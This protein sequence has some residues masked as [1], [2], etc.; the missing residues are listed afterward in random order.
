MNLWSSETLGKFRFS[1]ETIHSELC[2]KLKLFQYTSNFVKIFELQPS[3]CLPNIM[4]V[5]Q[6]Q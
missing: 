5:T 4:T 1:I 2:T 3:K 6:K